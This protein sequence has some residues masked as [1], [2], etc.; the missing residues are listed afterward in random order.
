LHEPRVVPAG[1]TE[2]DATQL[3]R[4]G[5]IGDPRI[6]AIAGLGSRVTRITSGINDRR[7]SDRAV[8]GARHVIA[9]PATDATSD[10]ERNP[11]R[12]RSSHV[13]P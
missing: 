10:Q 1:A 12:P 9:A 8:I 7:V 13:A 2:N 11:R 4:A 6:A 5:R 3:G